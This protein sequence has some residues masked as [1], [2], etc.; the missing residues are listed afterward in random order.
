MFVDPSL[1]SSPRDTRDRYL[2]R[3]HMMLKRYNEKALEQSAARV[4][5]LMAESR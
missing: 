4:D 5:E 1:Q 3:C 2:A